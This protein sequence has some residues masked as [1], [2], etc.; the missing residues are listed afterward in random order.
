MKVILCCP[1]DSPF[2]GPFMEKGPISVPLG[3]AYLGAFIQDISGIEVIGFDNNAMKLSKEE[4]RIFFQKEK[5]DIVAISI[6]TPTVYLAWEMA[7][8]VKEVIPGAIIVVGGV[9]CSALPEDT[10][11]EQAIDYGIAGEGEEAFR[12]FVLAIRGNHDPTDIKNLVFR[13]NGLVIVNP[14]RPR[15]KDLDRIPLPARNIFSEFNY[16][17]NVN[18]RVTSKRNTTIITSRGCP[19]SCI[20]CSKSIYG[21]DF[22]QRSPQNVIDEFLYLERNGFGEVLIVDDTFTINKKWILDFCGRYCRNNLKIVWNCHARVNTLDEEIVKA[23]KLANCSGLAFGIESGNPEML[24]RIDK[25][26]TLDQARMAIQLCR[27]YKLITLCSYIFGLPDDTWESVH[28]TLRVSLELDSDYANFSVLF[29]TPGSSIYAHLRNKNA[30]AEGKWD[31]CIGQSIALPDISI[32]ELTPLELQKV[33]KQAFR[34]F[35]F[36]PRYIIR[37]LLRVRSFMAFLGL[38]QG[39]FLVIL[40]QLQGALKKNQVSARI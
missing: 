39:A 28:D 30:I 16:G 8:T 20:F 38:L 7:R 6:L 25:R 40:F 37:R 4:Y 26:I 22:K 5:P 12:E 17:M 35:Y 9:H 33:L 15:I 14:R 1:S 18:R 21:E 34:R 3:L 13:K 23:L 19:Y 24:K 31:T 11:K 36:R 27:K 2:A 32:C 29:I 10:L